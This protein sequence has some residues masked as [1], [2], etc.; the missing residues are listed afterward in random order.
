MAISLIAAS[1]RT[2]QK[3]AQKLVDK[4]LSREN[5]REK[6]REREKE[7]CRDLKKDVQYAAKWLPSEASDD[8]KGVEDSL[9]EAYEI[10]E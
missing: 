2:T 1:S 6:K 7:K 8:R 3:V 4:S 10:L 9:S 5:D